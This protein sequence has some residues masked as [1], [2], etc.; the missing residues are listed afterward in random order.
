MPLPSPLTLTSFHIQG[1]YTHALNTAN[2]WVTQWTLSL[3]HNMMFLNFSHPMATFTY[4]EDH[5]FSRHP[6]IY[7]IDLLLLLKKGWFHKNSIHYKLM[8]NQCPMHW[9][10]MISDPLPNTCHTY[11]DKFYGQSIMRP[12]LVKII[13]P[14]EIISQ[15]IHV[16]VCDQLK[17]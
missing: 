13:K 17:F 10:T 6:L 2:E 4:V 8:R 14:W 11:N 12:T 5:L 15:Y 7:A 9:I 1:N 3:P 16:C